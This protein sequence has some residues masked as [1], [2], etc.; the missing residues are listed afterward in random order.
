MLFIAYTLKGI[1]EIYALNIILRNIFDAK[2]K[3]FTL[4]YIASG[5]Y[6]LITISHLLLAYQSQLNTLVAI[7]TTFFITCS[8]NLSRISR[9]LACIFSICIALYSEGIVF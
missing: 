2:I 8:Y 4:W 1:V 9:I 7:L 6:L 3:Q 5:L